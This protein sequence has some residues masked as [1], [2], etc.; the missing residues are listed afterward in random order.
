MV[1]SK[2]GKRESLVSNLK[3]DIIQSGKALNVEDQVNSVVWLTFSGSTEEVDVLAKQQA[4]M[5]LCCNGTAWL[6]DKN[7]RHVIRLKQGK[8]PCNFCCHFYLV[9]LLLGP[10]VFPCVSS[11]MQEL[12]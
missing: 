9:E 10:H 8:D 5:S 12:R 7:K 1:F 4:R 2:E 3:P 6:F 11:T